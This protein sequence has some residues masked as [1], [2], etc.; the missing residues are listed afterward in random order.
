MMFCKV[1]NVYMPLF[2][3][4]LKGKIVN[5]KNLIKPEE[6]DNNNCS[7]KYNMK[8]DNMK[9]DNMKRD[10][11]ISGGNISGG[12]NNNIRIIPQNP[13]LK[14]PSV[15]D[16]I[17]PKNGMAVDNNALYKELRNKNADNIENHNR[18]KKMNDEYNQLMGFKN[19]KK[20]KY[21]N[22]DIV[23]ERDKDLVLHKD[24]I[25]IGD[26]EYDLNVKG[27]D[28]NLKVGN[29]KID[30]TLSEIIYG[31]KDYNNKIL[32][33]R[34][35][36]AYSPSDK[37][38]GKY[39]NTIMEIFT[40]L[41]DYNKMLDNEYKVRAY[42]N[43]LNNIPT[44]T[45]FYMYKYP[46]N[47]KNREKFNKTLLRYMGEKLAD[48]I[49][50]IID[51]KKISEYIVA[52]KD[53]RIKLYNKIISIKGFGNSMAFKL[54]KEYNIKSL[55]EVKTK[56]NKLPLTKHQVLGITHHKDLSTKIKRDETLSIFEHIK[57]SIASSQ[58]VN[59]DELNENIHLVGSYRRMEK[60]QGD[61]DIL[62]SNGPLLSY[63]KFIQAIEN[64]GGFIDFIAKG[65]TK[66]SI[67]LRS[68]SGKNKKSSSNKV[69][70]VD[71]RIVEPISK[72]TALLYFTGSKSFNLWLRTQFKKIDWK[73]NEYFLKDDKENIRA[74]KC[75][76]D[77][78]KYINHPY[79]PPNER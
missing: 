9:G 78:F 15:L 56:K 43:A 40:T 55:E 39:I 12:S 75:E 29:I 22:Y 57:K 16:M 8:G 19:R 71:I 30:T 38:V 31:D 27:N 48:K 34:K 3:C 4:K 76:E 58:F 14:S 2:L 49:L 25:K 42:D 67:L 73:L 51:G 23:N 35:N 32:H 36:T 69:R 62:I 5:H 7:I 74:I 21:L 65:R 28:Y 68:K 24:P 1:D 79:I 63:D 59:D 44:I 60:L 6:L 10:G 45:E 53:D 17:L 61:I 64:M 11:I 47:L 20:T 54:I 70:Q 37:Y 41:R 26:K 66:I 46:L 33:K 52:K 18:F 13:Y 77:I 50:N 72:Y